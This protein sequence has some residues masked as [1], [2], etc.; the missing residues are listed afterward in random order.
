MPA[1]REAG[2]SPHAAPWLK[3]VAQDGGPRPKRPASGPNQRHLSKHPS[4]QRG[5]RADRSAAPSPGSTR[6]PM[7][8]CPRLCAPG[9]V[10]KAFFANFPQNEPRYDGRARSTVPARVPW[11][12]V[13]RHPNEQR[14]QTL[15]LAV[16]SLTWVGSEPRKTPPLLLSPPSHPLRRASPKSVAAIEPATI[17]PAPSHATASGTTPKSAKS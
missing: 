16:H 6:R 1:A 13:L 5:I 4:C 8:P 17:K 14:S 11:R 2:S 7:A 3:I 12:R 15:N 9:C 10:S